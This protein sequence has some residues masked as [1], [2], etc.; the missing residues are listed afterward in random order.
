MKRSVIALILIFILSL[1]GVG[2]VSADTII[3]AKKKVE[4]GF[5]WSSYLQAYYHFESGSDMTDSSSNGNDLTAANGPASSGTH[6]VDGS[7]SVRRDGTDDVI[8]RLDS[9][10]SAGFPGKAS[11]GNQNFLVTG[12]IYLNAVPSVDPYDIFSKYCAMNYERSWKSALTATSG[13]RIQ[14]SSSGNS[15]TLAKTFSSTDGEG[16]PDALVANKWYFIA[17]WH[18]QALDKYG[19]YIYN[20]TDDVASTFYSEAFTTGIYIGASSAAAF[21]IGNYRCSDGTNGQYL[22]GWVDRVVIYGWPDG[23]NPTESEIQTRIS[24]L[25][26]QTAP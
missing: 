25:Q 14:L 21:A 18:D 3:V 6:Y 4:S 26:A 23:V 20:S 15:Q 12:W 1:A 19:A 7:Y 9:S 16:W 5:S 11:T 22:D 17:M 8:R 13:F 24:A 10:L 2:V